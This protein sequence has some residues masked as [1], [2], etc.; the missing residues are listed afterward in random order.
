VELAPAFAR[1]YSRNSGSKL[2]ALQ[3]LRDFRGLETDLTI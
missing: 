1:W 3:T 2:H